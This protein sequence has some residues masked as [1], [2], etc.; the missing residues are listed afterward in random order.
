M[1]FRP[2]A[3]IFFGYC[4]EAENDLGGRTASDLNLSTRF[5]DADHTRMNREAVKEH[6][7]I[8]LPEW[9]PG[10][11]LER[12]EDRRYEQWREQNKQ[13]L[14]AWKQTNAGQEYG[15]KA[16]RVKE[17]LGELGI[18]LDAHGGDRASTPYLYLEEAEIQHD[19]DCRDMSFEPEKLDVPDD[20]IE[21]LQTIKAIFEL[22]V[23]GPD[24]YLVP[25]YG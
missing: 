25:Y 2:Y 15:E 5:E 4:G 7:G 19:W 11:E 3:T 23:E 6:L 16:L 13:A 10:Y 14:K 1:G 22:D 20:G 9:C 18:G 17:E 21:R 8:E 24:W 12:P